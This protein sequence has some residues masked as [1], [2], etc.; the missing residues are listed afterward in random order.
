MNITLTTDELT[1]LT[2]YLQP[3][4]QNEWLRDQGFIFR[5]AADGRARV[6]RSHYLKQMGG[7]THEFTRAKTSPDFSSLE[8]K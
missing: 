3:K 2:G 7:L 8:K 6:D 4:K 1:E 5:V